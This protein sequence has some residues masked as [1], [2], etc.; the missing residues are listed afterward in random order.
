MGTNEKSLLRL[1]LPPQM[2][3]PSDHGE[4]TDLAKRFFIYCR[5]GEGKRRERE[6]E[7]ERERDSA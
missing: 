1:R 7:R 3:A 6:R 5:V 2:Y 4:R